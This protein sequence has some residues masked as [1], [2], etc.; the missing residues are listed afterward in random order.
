[1]EWKCSVYEEICE[2]AGVPHKDKLAAR[3]HQKNF[4]RT[5]ALHPL[6]GITGASDALSVQPIAQLVAEEAESVRALALVSRDVLNCF[7]ALATQFPYM[8]SL[9]HCVK[10]LQGH[11]SNASALARTDGVCW[12]TSVVVVVDLGANVLDDDDDDDSIKLFLHK[13]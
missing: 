13:F 4:A 10:Q 11:Q 8:R 5:I 12:W 2:A 1:M 9:L 7:R 3:R 6:G